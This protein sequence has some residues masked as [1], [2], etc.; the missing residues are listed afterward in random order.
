MCAV[1]L[2][3]SAVA[4][5]TGA[6]FSDNWNT[7]PNE[8]D[9]NHSRLWEWRDPQILRA[10]YRRESAELQFVQLDVIQTDGPCGRPMTR[11]E[12]IALS[13]VFLITLPAVTSR[14]YASD[15]IQY[16]AWLRSLAFDRDAD[17]QNEYQY[18]YDAGVSRSPEFHETFLERQTPSGRRMNF[19]TLGSALLWAPFYAVG[20]LAALLSGPPLTGTSRPYIVAVS[21]G[22][23]VY[24]FLAVLLSAAA[25]RRVVGR[26]LTASLLVAIGTPLVFYSYVAPVFGHATSAFAVSLMVWVWLHVRDRWTLRGALALGLAGGLVAIVREQDALLALA[27]TLD[28]VWFA[29]SK[30]RARSGSTANVR[31]LVQA[32]IAGV[33]LRARISAA[34]AGLRVNQRRRQAGCDRRAKAHMVVAACHRRGV[35]PGARPARL[36][37][38]CCDRA[39]RAGA[40]RHQ[41]H[42]TS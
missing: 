20:H 31:S 8:I 10:A 21:L 32:A 3:W 11:R 28:F 22:S 1:L 41:S 5:G 39:H 34:G 35:R 37:A 2:V 17:F 38:A 18:F 26:G 36:D 29:W 23:A 33:R 14:L 27:P 9:K 6:F 24:G 12:I 7:S 25:A 16:Y 15:E 40:A 19:T 30:T 42:R 13:L 4:A